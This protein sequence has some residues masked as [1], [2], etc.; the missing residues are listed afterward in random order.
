[1]GLIEATSIP[2]ASVF[3]NHDSSSIMEA[4]TS[5]ATES[6]FLL[7]SDGDAGGMMENAGGIL[8]NIA[9]GVTAIIFLLAGL[10]YLTASIIVPAAA[11]ELE[12]ECKE[13]APELW[14]EYTARL[15]PGQQMS[16]R[17]D[18][19][20]EMGMKLQPLLEAKIAAMDNEGAE[21]GSGVLPTALETTMNPMTSA[22]PAPKETEE[23]AT[24]ITL[25]SADQWDDEEKSTKK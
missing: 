12:Q 13:L 22:A 23:E 8:Q 4:S 16:Q 14:D 5:R 7:L 1:M 18:L 19:M 3:S 20:Q 2:P 25:T 24:V 11:K 9:I 10:T 15:E 6:V 21:E 17:P